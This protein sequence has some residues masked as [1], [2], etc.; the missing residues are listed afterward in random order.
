M[1]ERD[2]VVQLLE[3]FEKSNAWPTVWIINALRTKWGTVY[4]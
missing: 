4:S 3:E 1:R 2:E